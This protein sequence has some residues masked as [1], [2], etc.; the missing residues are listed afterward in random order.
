M[1]TT[2]FQIKMENMNPEMP[3]KSTKIL[4]Y[5]FLAREWE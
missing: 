2:D 5:S 4:R 1:K 3:E